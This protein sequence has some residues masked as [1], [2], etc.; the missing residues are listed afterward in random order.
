MEGISQRLFRDRGREQT[1]TMVDEVGVVFNVA[2]RARG[3]G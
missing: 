3:N 2:S 1:G